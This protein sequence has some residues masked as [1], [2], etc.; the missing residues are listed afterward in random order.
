MR[1]PTIV[2]SIILAGLTVAAYLLGYLLGH[3]SAWL[4]QQHC[5]EDAV[6]VWDGERH[7]ICVS[8]DELGIT[9]QDAYQAGQR[10]D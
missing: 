10:A 3:D 5:P 7:T 2:V 8:A 9:P 6:L 1:L 4:D